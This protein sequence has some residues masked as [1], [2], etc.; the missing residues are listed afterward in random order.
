[1]LMNPTYD[2]SESRITIHFSVTFICVLA[3]SEHGSP[4]Y[5]KIPPL[6][7]WQSQTF[8]LKA[9]IPAKHFNK[10]NCHYPRQQTDINVDSR[11][12]HDFE[13]GAHS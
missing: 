13:R 6:E 2:H 9:P 8:W 5:W 3:D 10:L 11:G 7:N 1:M 4:P 12:I